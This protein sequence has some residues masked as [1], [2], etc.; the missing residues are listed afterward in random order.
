MPFSALLKL[1]CCV[2]LFIYSEGKDSSHWIGKLW[3]GRDWSKR[4][5][6]TPWSEQ[7]NGQPWGERPNGRSW[8]EQRNGRSWSSAGNGGKSCFG[9][10]TCDMSDCTSNCMCFGGGELSLASCLDLSNLP[11]SYLTSST[12][13]TYN[14]FKIQPPV[15]CRP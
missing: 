3:Q 1:Q 10:Q 5:D 8:S 6:G 9:G 4:A 13:S 7:S 15:P 12:S 14:F 11:S 2:F